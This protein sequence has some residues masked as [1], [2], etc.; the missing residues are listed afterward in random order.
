MI[1]SGRGYRCES[2]PTGALFFSKLTILTDYGRAR[3]LPGVKELFTEL[4][5]PAPSED[6]N[7]HE[8]ARYK[9]DER[10][11]GRPPAAG[12]RD[13]DEDELLAWEAQKE[14]EQQTGDTAA[15]TAPRIEHPIPVF[16]QVVAADVEALLL[17]KHKADLLARYAEV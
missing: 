8:F 14:R 15:I 11:Y 16:G 4:A 2:C 13:K 3:E 5:A 7:K 17:E 1:A 12:T 10:Y 6:R 9:I